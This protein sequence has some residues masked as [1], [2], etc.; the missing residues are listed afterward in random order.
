VSIEVMIKLVR[1]DLTNA[2]SCSHA[3]LHNR[4]FPAPAPALIDPSTPERRSAVQRPYP[5]HTLHSEYEPPPSP[6]SS[7]SRSMRSQRRHGVIEPYR[8]IR[9]ESTTEDSDLTEEDSTPRRMPNIRDLRSV[10]ATSFGTFA[11]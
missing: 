1:L 2:L 5:G 7:A 8:Y 4:I 6:T 9:D 11:Q 10:T 3:P